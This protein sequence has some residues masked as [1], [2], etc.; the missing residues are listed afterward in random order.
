MS[1]LTFSDAQQMYDLLAADKH[2]YNRNMWDY[3]ALYDNS[4]SIGVY[5]ISM[6]HAKALGCLCVPSRPAFWLSKFTVF[7]RTVYSPSEALD[8]CSRV[9]KTAGW[10]L[11]T[12]LVATY[13]F[14]K[15]T[16]TVLN[17][18][19]RAELVRQRGADSGIS[20]IP[21]SYSTHDE[22]RFMY[23]SEC[24]GYRHPSLRD[25]IWTA[26]VEALRKNYQPPDP[27]LNPNLER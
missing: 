8:W 15:L 11:S 27:L 14:D 19:E 22:A 16:G 13:Y 6:E 21:G 17:E 18:S 24:D 3:A 1:F 12:E 23:E 5:H 2:I 7:P 4:G 9:Y 20:L 10:Q 25:Q 26:S